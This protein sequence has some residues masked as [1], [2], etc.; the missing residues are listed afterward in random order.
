YLQIEIEDELGLS[1]ASI[2]TPIEVIVQASPRGLS[3]LFAER[4]LL[5][6]AA[7]LVAG[8]V[9]LTAAIAGRRS[10]RLWETRRKRKLEADPLHQKV[11]IR[12]EPSL[13]PG[14]SMRVAQPPHTRWGQPAAT[15]QQQ[16]ESSAPAQFIRITD[17]GQPIPAGNM[18]ITRSE[19]TIG[20]DPRQAV[21]VIDSPTVNP[22]HARLYQTPQGGY[23][24]VDAGSVAG[25][26]V[27]YTPVSRQGVHLEHGDL[28]QIG[29]AAF[30]FELG[31]PVET[32]RPTTTPHK[33]E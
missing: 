19:I 17:N 14:R 11:K 30:R 3:D 31:S 1:Q 33:E 16:P 26:W 21:F 2:Q 32:R 4:P 10:L 28:I 27:N 23:I 29:N 20:S 24:L 13:Q 5:I 22:L 8:G 9:L 12:Q 6:A 25:T 18:P 15:P 7:V